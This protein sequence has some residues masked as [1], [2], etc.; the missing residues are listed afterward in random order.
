MTPDAPEYYTRP[1]TPLSPLPFYPPQPSN[2]PVIQNQIDPIFNMT[3]THTETANI[4]EL[5]EQSHADTQLAT[6]D[7][8]M[9]TVDHTSFSDP[10]DEEESAVEDVTKA[11]VSKSTDTDDDYAM[12][13]D[14]DG[15]ETSSRND[16][17]SAN[18]EQ[19]SQPLPPPVSDIVETLPSDVPD[20]SPSITTQD[21]QEN[22]PHSLPTTSTFSLTAATPRDAPVADESNVIQ[23]P[24]ETQQS[25]AQPHIYEDV[26]NGGIDIQQL[27][28]NITATAEANATPTSANTSNSNFPF[29]SSGLPAHSSLPPRPQI[30]QKPS[31]H[32]P[33]TPQY[34]TGPPGYPPP[35][36]S[37]LRPPGVP[38]A[39]GTSTDAR[40]ALP[41]PPPASFQPPPSHI[42]PGHVN[43]VYPQ[44]QRGATQERPGAGIDATDALDEGEVT[45]GP[46]VQ[47]LYDEFLA[48]ER[49]YV[50]E[51]LWDRFPVGSRLFIGEI[52]PP[53]KSISYLIMSRE[54]AYGE[55]HQA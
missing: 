38:P 53:M 49:M 25:Q 10:Y 47:K 27:L 9:D 12:T 46:S 18:T 21:R 55:G 6:A 42:Q 14:S 3:S 7:N 2:I 41:P 17:S 32:L 34:Q 48:D 31:L 40:N 15:E 23:A 43:Q 54:F 28:D 13:F 35:G 29:S 51:G 4:P 24:T 20:T 26:S 45:W 33:Y 11:Q 19:E 5:S 16:V 37:S 8:D 52:Y 44:T 1:T 22:L 39:P 30:T 36:L 50:N